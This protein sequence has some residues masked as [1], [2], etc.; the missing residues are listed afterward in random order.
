MGGHAVLSNAGQWGT[1]LATAPTRPPLPME[2]SQDFEEMLHDTDLVFTH[3]DPV[4][5]CCSFLSSSLAAFECPLT[6]KTAEGS[7]HITKR[8]AKA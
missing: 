4:V 8:E 3:P 2:V 5:L 7:S 6:P 1:A